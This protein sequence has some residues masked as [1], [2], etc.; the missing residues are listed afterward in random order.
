M[1][2]EVDDF[3]SRDDVS[4]LEAELEME[5]PP[6]SESVLD[7]EFTSGFARMSRK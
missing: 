5:R 7:E 4:E 3:E 2:E 6:L 1:R